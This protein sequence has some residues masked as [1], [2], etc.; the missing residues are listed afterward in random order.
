MA[1]PSAPNR[2]K[3]LR[4]LQSLM[5]TYNALLNIDLRNAFNEANRHAAF[6]AI[7]V[8]ASRTY[9]DGRVKI[10]DQLPH[11]G[12]VNEFFLCF[13][14]MHQCPSTLWYIDQ[15]GTVHHVEC[16]TGGQQGDPLEMMRFCSS[17]HP[18]LG[19]VMARNLQARA[20]VFTD[21]GFVYDSLS[22]ALHIWVELSNVLINDADLAMQLDK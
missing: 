16:T 19:R 4:V 13:K 10:G 20:V 17:I 11:L 18:I 5:V 7:I 1:P 3:R 9:V 8:K 14:A 2:C 6:D 21:D 12:A 22:S 15:K